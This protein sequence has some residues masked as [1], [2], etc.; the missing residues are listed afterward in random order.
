MTQ[1]PVSIASY[2]F[3]AMKADECLDVF[4]YL[5]LLYSRYRVG[6]A[7]IW[8]GFLPTL[9]V[10]FLKK[11][12]AE[13]DRRGIEL[14]NLCVDGPHLW[15]DDAA[16]REQHH[17]LALEYIR[18]AEILGARTIRIDMGCQ[19][20][21][22]SP[23]AFDYIAKTYLEYAHICFEAGMRIGPENHWGASRVPANL[24]KVQ[25]AVNHPGYG[26]LLHF[27]NFAEEL[28][29]GYAT[30]IPKAMH[31][32]IAADTIPVAKGIIRRLAAAGYEGTYS[33]EHHSGALELER[34]EWQ[35]GSLRAILAEL[36]QEGLQSPTKSDYFH[37]IY[38]P[39]K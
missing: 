37:S 27:E 24:K 12:R 14:A 21:E 30:V 39:N 23:E 13:M 22:L 19:S 15:V 17:A 7:D 25:E 2:S 16:E 38:Y 33:V 6:Y 20:N 8:S 5:E 1:F 26:H 28:E 9:E 32:H 35:L 10:S 34:V 29:L 36:M 11:V 4:G 31:T 3:H 18:A